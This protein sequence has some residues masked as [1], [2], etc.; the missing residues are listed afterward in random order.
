M[1]KERLIQTF[2]DLVKTDSP[3]KKEKQIAIK[4]QGILEK[5]GFETYFD[6]AY[7]PTGS[8]TG[9]LIARLSGN[10]NV[11]AI[12]LGA[13]MDTVMPGENINPQIRN[14]IIKSDGT[15]ILGADDKAGITAIIEGIKYIKENKIPHGDIEVV[16][17]ICEE[18]GLLGAK[19]LDS[20]K[21]NSKYAFI[22]DCS[23]KV[24]TVITKGPAEMRINTKIIGKSAH[25]GLSPEKGIS[26]IQV[27]AEAINNMKL[28]RID[29]ETTANVGIIRG[30]LAT[31]IVCDLVEIKSEARSLSKEKLAKQVDHMV[32]CFKKACD[33]F[34]AKLEMHVEESYPG[35]SIDENDPILDV[36]KMAMKR[37]GVEYSPKSTGGGSDANILNGAGIKAVT[38]GTGMT[39]CH[40]TEEYITLESLEKTTIL[41]ASLIQEIQ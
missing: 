23:G 10:K 14:G 3:S 1:N 25:A 9:N 22:F 7:I 11:Q 12:M 16:F 4:L 37:S 28:L 24:G 34:S 17:T 21:I 39:N 5:M 13:H 20:S 2:I 15:T 41:V 33:N 32:N 35:F 6:D 18:I 40:S 30:G 36:V 8:D 38:L 19:H 26:S 29:E 31:N 27:A